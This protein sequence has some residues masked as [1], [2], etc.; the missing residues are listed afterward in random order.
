MTAKIHVDVV[1]TS[2]EGAVTLTKQEALKFWVNYDGPANTVR[3]SLNQSSVTDDGTGLFD[4]VYT[5]N[6]ADAN[7]CKQGMVTQVSGGTSSA[8]GCSARKA[9]T[10]ETNQSAMTYFENNSNTFLDVEYA[11]ASSNGDLA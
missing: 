4:Y 3:D 7:Y 10:Q 6:F 8:A 2:S 9:S 5:T 1:Q 11:Y